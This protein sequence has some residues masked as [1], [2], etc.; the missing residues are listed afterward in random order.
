MACP[1]RSFNETEP[2]SFP[3]PFLLVGDGPPTERNLKALGTRLKRNEIHLLLF[4]TR[5][6]AFICAKNQKEKMRKGLKG[7]SILSYVFVAG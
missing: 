4:I 3:G 1:M 5:K 2:N 7:V 6:Y